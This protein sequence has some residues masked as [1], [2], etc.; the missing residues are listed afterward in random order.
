M[1]ESRIIG[2]VEATVRSV[3]TVPGE[4]KLLVRLEPDDG[5]F[6]PDDEIIMIVPATEIVAVTP[7]RT[8]KVAI[9]SPS[10]A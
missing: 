3:E 6:C 9:L 4:D 2:E 10:D 7:G 5:S 1:A 8:V